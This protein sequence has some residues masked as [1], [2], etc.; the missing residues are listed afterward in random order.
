MRSDDHDHF[1][2][3]DVNKHDNNDND[4]N[5]NAAWMRCWRRRTTLYREHQLLR[6]RW[7]L[8]ERQPDG[9]C[10]SGTA[11]NDDH[12]YDNND[13]EH[14]DDNYQHPHDHDDDV[15]RR[16]QQRRTMR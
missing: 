6:W 15:H 16:L 8:H 7:R 4:D 10:L 11:D 1:T 5:H 14:D 3:T 13:D 9:S 2:T 12:H